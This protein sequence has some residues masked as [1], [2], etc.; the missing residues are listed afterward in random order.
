MSTEPTTR[1]SSVQPEV[2]LGRVSGVFGVSGEVRLF[3]HNPDSGWLS[4]GREVTLVAPDGRRRVVHLRARPGAGKRILG[5]I[6]GVSNRDDAAA[7][8]D[9][10]VVVPR[11][12]LPGL[13]PG[14]YYLWQVEGAAVEIDGKPVGRV[15]RVHSSG[16]VE[17]LEIDAGRREPVFVPS[18]EAFVERVD[19]EQRVVLLKPGALEE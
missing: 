16:P 2:E 13:E 1:R 12:E 6:R 14:E 17:I 11:D 9:W 5:Q 18:V 4:E 15:V 3:L 19:V 8:Q 7:L 10:R